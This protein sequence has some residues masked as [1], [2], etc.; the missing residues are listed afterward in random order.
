M[1]RAASAVAGAAGE[2]KAQMPEVASTTRTAMAEV[3]REMKAGSDEALTTG[4]TLSFGVALGL[5]LG[6]APRLLVGIAL[7]PA[8]AMAMTLWDRRTRGAKAGATRT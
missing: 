2:I 3:Q 5:L 6:G 4:A 7:L 1:S 8:A